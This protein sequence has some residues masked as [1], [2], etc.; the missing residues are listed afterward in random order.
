MS[1]PP[2][3]SA[4]S[5][6]SAPGIPQPVIL[7]GPSLPPSLPAGTKFTSPG[8]G[9]LPPPQVGMGENIPFPTPVIPPGVGPIYDTPN[10]VTGSPT[11][12]TPESLFPALT[13][14]P[15]MQPIVLTAIFKQGTVP[16]PLPTTPGVAPIVDGGWTWGATPPNGE[17]G[18]EEPEP[19]AVSQ[20]QPAVRATPKPKAKRRR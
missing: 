12:P 11:V 13:T 9:W 17:N 15:P 10:F 18:E 19:A 5:P 16:P 3:T 4:P 1:D 7:G 6:P 8:W 20:L 14:N 2:I